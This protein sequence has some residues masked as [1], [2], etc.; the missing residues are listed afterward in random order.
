MGKNEKKKNNFEKHF[1]NLRSKI[2]IWDSSNP[3]AEEYVRSCN[4]L[5]RRL[6]YL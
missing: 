1:R 4:I 2:R 3:L 6:K 5:R